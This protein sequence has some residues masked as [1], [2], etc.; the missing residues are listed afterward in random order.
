[1]EYDTVLHQGSLNI[2]NR[3][4]LR[5]AQAKGGFIAKIQEGAQ[6]RKEHLASWR[7]DTQL[8]RALWSLFSATKAGFQDDS[9]ESTTGD[10]HIKIIAVLGLYPINHFL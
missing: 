6:G 3:N 5:V 8:H 4:S 2:R 10:L 7:L 9:P 1:M